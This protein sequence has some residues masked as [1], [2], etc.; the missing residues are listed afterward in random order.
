MAGV[1]L[2]RLA[3]SIPAFPFAVAGAQHGFAPFGT[4]DFVA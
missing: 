2:V 1:R 3:V 4:P